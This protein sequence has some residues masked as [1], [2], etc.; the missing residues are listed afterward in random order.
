VNN[1]TAVAS[2]PSGRRADADA[3]RPALRERLEPLGAA[4]RPLT[5][6]AIVLVAVLSITGLVLTHA[7]D[8]SRMVGWDVDIERWLL[9]HR[10]SALDAFAEGG[11]W[12][13]ETF[14]VPVVL[15]IA[16]VIAWRVSSRVAA[17]IFLIAAVGGEKLI[18][19][20]SSLVVGRDRPPIPTVGTSYA[21]S[22]FP[23]GHVA[24]AITLYGSIALLI[25][26]ERSNAVRRWLL[27]VVA[28]IAAIVGACRMYC[29]FHY[30]SDVIAGLVLGTVWL[31]VVY[32]TVLVR[33][34]S[35]RRGELSRA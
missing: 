21:T 17:P 34:P 8:G 16:V 22:S 11:T 35:W 13:S 3:G 27:A 25:A 7:L 28:L 33:S 12:F 31:T 26:L 4:W 15:L 1:H 5:A 20:V 9:D 24:S 6:T 30:L 29:G 14:V 32:R 2:R 23:S 10:T 19:F 18:Y